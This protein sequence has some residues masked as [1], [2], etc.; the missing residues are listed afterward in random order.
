MGKKVLVKLLPNALN[1][2]LRDM[3]EGKVYEGYIPEKGEIDSSGYPVMRDDELWIEKDDAGDD[4]VTYISGN[5]EIVG[6]K[7]ED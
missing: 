1:Y 2:V 3:T 4:V 7:N 5:F 6:F